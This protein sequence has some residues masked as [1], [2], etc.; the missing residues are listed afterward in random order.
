MFAGLLC[1]PVKG[2]AK[3][4]IAVVVAGAQ[5]EGEDDERRLLGWVSRLCL[6]VGTRCERML[7]WASKISSSHKN[8]AE[9]VEQSLCLSVSDVAQRRANG[10]SCF[11]DAKPGVHLELLLSSGLVGDE[12]EI[13]VQ[14]A[15]VRV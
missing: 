15:V 14:A 2:L 8:Q 3:A 7:K 12:I 13:E 6:T 9:R 10:G 4:S 5:A 11:P 1:T